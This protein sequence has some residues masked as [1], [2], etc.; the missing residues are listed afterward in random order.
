MQRVRLKRP[1]DDVLKAI[2]EQDCEFNRHRHNIQWARFNTTA[3]IEGGALYGAFQAHGLAFIERIGILTA[4]TILVAL[5]FLLIL[6]DEIDGAA[7][8]DRIREYEKQRP[9]RPRHP[10][11]GKWAIRAA[12]IVIM[13]F[14]LAAIWRIA[15]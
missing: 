3:L 13:F 7:H 10:F 2:Y 1:T 5:N 4:V 11:W 12:L 8:R 6:S 14:N 15:C 9:F